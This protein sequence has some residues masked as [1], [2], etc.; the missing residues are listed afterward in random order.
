MN[1]SL[2]RFTDSGKTK[3]HSTRD[4][5]TYL[6]RKQYLNVTKALV[7]GIEAKDSRNNNIAGRN[8]NTIRVMV[9]TSYKVILTRCWWY[10]DTFI[11]LS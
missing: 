6:S 3:A 4:R 2:Q 9:S 5:E 7:L 1:K 10:L 11:T 8:K